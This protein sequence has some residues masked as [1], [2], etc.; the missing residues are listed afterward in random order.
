[1]QNNRFISYKLI[2]ISFLTIMFGSLLSTFLSTPQIQY[3]SPIGS[4][5]A[6]ESRVYRNVKS[7]EKL[8]QTPEEQIQSLQDMFL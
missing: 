7:L 3:A 1:M 8:Q 5:T 2:L 6:G 4:E